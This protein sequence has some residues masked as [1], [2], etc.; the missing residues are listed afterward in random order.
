MVRSFR[1]QYNLP[2]FI[3]I[4]AGPGGKGNFLEM[5]KQLKDPAQGGLRA[6]VFDRIRMPD[7][8]SSDQASIKWM[9][10]LSGDAGT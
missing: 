9:P 2:D 4:V 6:H 5:E 1:S 10:R 3:F 7:Y 8:L